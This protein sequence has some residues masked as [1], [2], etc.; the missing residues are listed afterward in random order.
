MTTNRSGRGSFF[1]D[2]DL[3]LLHRLEKRALHLGGRAVDFVRQHQVREDGTELGG[4]LAPVL[5]VDDGADEIG[6]QEV[7]RELDE[8]KLG[9]DGV[10]EGADGERLGEAGHALD[11][12]MALREHR[13]HHALQ[14][15]VLADDN[16]LHLVEDVFHSCSCCV[17]LLRRA[18]RLAWLLVGIGGRVSGGG[19]FAPLGPSGAPRGGPPPGLPTNEPGATFPS[20]DTWRPVRAVRANASARAT[21]QPLAKALAWPGDGATTRRPSP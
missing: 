8:G 2:G 21:S 11:Q 9:V 20:D 13:H 4:E 5:V 17:F 1:A 14:E 16:L 18:A 6:R 10:A 3:P 7:G 15:M 19:R 12:Q